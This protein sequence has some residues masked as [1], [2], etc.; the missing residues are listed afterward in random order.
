MSAPKHDAAGE[1]PLA[2]WAVWL[3]ALPASRVGIGLGLGCGCRSRSNEGALMHSW[4]TPLVT[5]AQLCDAQSVHV[6][7]WH[8]PG[9]NSYPVHSAT[10]LHFSAHSS[11]V[12]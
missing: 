8:E 12:E 7:M 10:E 4:Y 2:V 11:L 5:S 6:L 1:P 9:L 3:S